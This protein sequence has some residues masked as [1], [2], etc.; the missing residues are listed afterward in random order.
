MTIHDTVYGTGHL[1]HN[2]TATSIAAAESMEQDA[3]TMRRKVLAYI[4]ESGMH[5][6]TDDDIQRALQMSGDCERPR[7]GELL[8][9]L[10]IEQTGEIRRTSKGR[11]AKVWHAT[12]AG[13]LALQEAA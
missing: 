6:A 10:L 3:P 11:E 5:G 13:R 7:R 8:T 4:V 1:P 9:A 2:G 12:M